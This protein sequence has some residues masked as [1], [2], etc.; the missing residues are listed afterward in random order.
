M[1]RF[2]PFRDL[3]R[4]TEQVSRQTRSLLAMDAIRNDQQVNIYIDV[5]GVASDDIEVSVEQNELTVNVERR[6]N[7]SDWQV[8]TSERPQGTFTRR[9]VLGDALD[10]DRLQAHMSDGVLEIT[11]PVSERSRQR[12]IDVGSGGRSREAI[13]TSGR[14]SDES[15]NPADQG[16]NA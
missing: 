7:D 1:M 11:I 15:A 9:L 3:D 10:L 14:P 12:R 6:W 2:D 13:E 5:P 8:I 4:L 16:S